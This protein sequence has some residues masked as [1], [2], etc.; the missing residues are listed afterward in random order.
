MLSELRSW[1]RQHHIAAKFANE[2]W[3]ALE[4][5]TV[6]LPAA[7]TWGQVVG[8]LL[9]DVDRIQQ[10]RGRLATQIE[11][12]F[13]SHPLGKV[14]V[15]LCG[16]GSRTGARTLAEIGDPIRFKDGSRLASYAGLSPTDWRSGSSINGAFQ[17][18]G[19]NVIHAMLT[20]AR[21]LRSLTLQEICRSSLAT[22]QQHPKES[23]P[24]G[25][26]GKN[27]L[28]FVGAVNVDRLQRPVD[29]PSLL[30]TGRFRRSW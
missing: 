21:P 30:S 16:F 19:G 23:R 9:A 6:T 10:Q 5:Q 22:R 8:E 12:A 18:R 11:E 25:K 7:E 29:D 24:M 20:T 26:V 17:H 28:A 27:P 3:L 14:L 2:I 15:T 1:R 13:L 4:A